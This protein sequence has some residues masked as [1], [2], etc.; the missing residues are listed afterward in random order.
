MILS[1]AYFIYPVAIF[2]AQS[3]FFLSDLSIY[4]PAKLEFYFQEPQH[5]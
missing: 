1:N 3:I 4:F 2:H 5:H